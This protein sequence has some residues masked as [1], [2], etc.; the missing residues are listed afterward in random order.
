M[1]K[2]AENADPEDYPPLFFIV[3][4]PNWSCTIESQPIYAELYTEDVLLDVASRAHLVMIGQSKND[5]FKVLEGQQPKLS[6]VFGITLKGEKDDP[7]LVPTS[8]VLANNGF[9][10][11]SLE[12]EKLSQNLAA[13]QK[14]KKKK[15]IKKSKPTQKS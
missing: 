15:S 3:E 11:E 8:I 14:Q 12:I 6:I 5:T 4:G 10:K 9:Y 2:V 7:I 1:A 13:E